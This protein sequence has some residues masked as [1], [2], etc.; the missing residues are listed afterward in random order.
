MSKAVTVDAQCVQRLY[1]SDRTF[2][3]LLR[4]EVLTQLQG[5][6]AEAAYQAQCEEQARRVAS[7]G[8]ASHV[9]SPLSGGVVCEAGAGGAEDA[10]EVLRLLD[11]TL[12]S[13]DAL[14]ASVGADELRGGVER[15][16]RAGAR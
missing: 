9:A 15:S 5:L 14:F 4:N 13:F 11:A 12:G 2:R 16:A 8:P 1:T 6:E 10:A 3:T 7:S